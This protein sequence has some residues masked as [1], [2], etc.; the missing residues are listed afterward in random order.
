MNLLT[1]INSKFLENKTNLYFFI[2]LIS[3]ISRSIIAYFFGDRVL[4]NEWGVLVY[5][6]YNFGEFSLLKFND[7]FIP[8]LWMPPIY[9]YFIYIHALI[10]GLNDNL[11]TS[12]IITQI[13]LSSLTSVI[14]FKLLLNFFK[15]KLSLFGAITFSLFPIIIFAPSQIS[16]VTIYLFLF[17][18]F[19]FLFFRLTKNQSN[20]NLILVAIISGVLMLTRRDFILI[21]LF[22]IFF[23]ILFFKA[24]F[25]KMILLFLLTTLTISPYLIRN[26]FAFDKV[27]IHSGFGYN[28]WKSYNPEAK[29]EGTLEGIYDNDLKQKIDKIEK[30]ILYRIN[31]DKIFLNTAKKFILDDPSRYINLF[32]K[33]IYSFYFFDNNSSQKNYYSFFH[34]YPNSIIAILSIF[35]LIVCSKKNKEYN[36]LILS[37][38]L[39]ILVYSSFSILP[40]YKIYILPFQIILSLSLL[41]FFINKLSKKN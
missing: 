23:L 25:K 12:V 16:S 29:V 37:L 34:I 26:Y 8:N 32:F 14:F 38:I 41:E 28:L 35:G 15:K 31:H 4:E 7:L 2:F 21:Y 39:L 9:G 20:K 36:Y 30:N 40:R 11:I 3:A 13:I 22:S 19:F 10:F 6:L 1:I 33:R 18:S 5:N 27:I 17:I 24:D